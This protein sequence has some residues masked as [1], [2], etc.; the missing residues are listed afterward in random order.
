[1][2]PDVQQLIE[3][4]LQKYQFNKCVAIDW[5]LK[6]MPWKRYLAF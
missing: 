3:Q 1:M 2:V 6:L 5:T 4:Q